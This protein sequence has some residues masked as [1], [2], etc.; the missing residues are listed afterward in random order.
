MHDVGLPGPCVCLLV[1]YVITWGGEI[2]SLFPKFGASSPNHS[3]DYP[4]AQNIS[5]TAISMSQVLGVVVIAR[6]GDRM[7]YYQDPKNYAGSFTE[8]TALGEVMTYS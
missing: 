7:G 3:S 8:T 1:A 2:L 4:S 5:K 6:N